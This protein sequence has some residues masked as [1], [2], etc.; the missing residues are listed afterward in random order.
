MMEVIRHW[1]VVLV[2]LTL[3]GLVCA[4]ALPLAIS[5]RGGTAPSIFLAESPVRATAAVLAAGAVA[6]IVAVVVGRLINAAV[7]LFVMGW[8]LAVFAMRTDTVR[9]VILSGEAGLW[10]IAAETLF[11]AA[12]ALALTMLM[13][14]L[15][16]PLKDIHPREFEAPPHPLWSADALKCAAA[17]VLV[18]PVVLLLARS[19]MKGQV[20]T[21]AFFG[22]VAAGLVGRL[23]APH[24]QPVLLFATPCAAGALG[25]LAG[26]FML[27][28]Q[29]L[30][31]AFI[32]HELPPLCLPMPMDYA[33]ASL[34]G[35]AFGLGWARTFL[36]HEDEAAEPTAKGAMPHPAPGDG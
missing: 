24:V 13:F 19:P 1:T 14:R 30:E 33:G 2:G 9:E 17:G 3:T 12:V 28:Q 18:I 36:H 25:H 8:G 23:L 11:W 5:P 27:G 26:R 22:A 29:S 7:G 16:G 15:A 20:L 21:A 32:A 34:M 35:V 10:L 6:F 4:A 31:S